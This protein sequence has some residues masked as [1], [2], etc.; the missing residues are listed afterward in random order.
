MT[1]LLEVPTDWV[2][3]VVFGLGVIYAGWMLWDEIRNH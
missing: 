2:A 3:I 1:W